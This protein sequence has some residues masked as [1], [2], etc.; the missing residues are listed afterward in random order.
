MSSDARWF[1]FYAAASAPWVVI[2]LQ[3]IADLTP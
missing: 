3:A 1:V 2:A